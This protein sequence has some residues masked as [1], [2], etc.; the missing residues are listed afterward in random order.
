MSFKIR[1][2][3]GGGAWSLIQARV[4]MDIYGDIGGHEL[5]RQFD[6]VIANSGGS[7]VLACLCN[8]MKP[9]EIIKIFANKSN[10]EQVFS[11]LTFWEN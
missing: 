11:K 3:D 6:M 7:L 9:S 5:L 2:M 4:L 8:D 1:S 10:R